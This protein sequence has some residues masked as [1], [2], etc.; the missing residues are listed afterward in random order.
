MTI[1]SASVSTEAYE[2]LA[3]ALRGDLIQ[4]ADPGYD[5]ARAVYNA[6]I[7]KHPLLIARCADVGDVIAAV[8]FGTCVPMR[9]G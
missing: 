6:M 2:Q 7:D 5:A 8:N 9:W 1:T 4:P 3:A